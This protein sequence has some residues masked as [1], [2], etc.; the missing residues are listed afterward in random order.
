LDINHTIKLYS[1]GIEDL[2]QCLPAIFSATNKSKYE[3]HYQTR[4]EEGIPPSLAHELT[5]TRGLFAVADIIEIAHIRKMKTSQV[6][7]LYFLIGE[8]LDLPWVRTQVII[9]SAENHWEALSREAL[10][11]DLDWQQRQLTDGLIGFKAKNMN[12]QDLITTWGRVHAPLIERWRSILVDLRSSNSLTY[13]MFFVAIR[14]LLDLTQTTLQ[15]H[16][17]LGPVDNASLRSKKRDFRAV[18]PSLQESK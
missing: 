17:E 12:L 6:A 5:V 15:S 1:Q 13:I 3:D 16:F 18:L 2:K 11:D 14:E 10:R 8:F 9:H 4:L 7:E